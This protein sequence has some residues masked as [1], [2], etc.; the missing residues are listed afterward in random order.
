MHRPRHQEFLARVAS[1]PRHGIGLSV[2]VYSPDIGELVGALRRAQLPVRYLEMFKAHP[3]AL[4]AVRSNIPDLAFEYHGE[5]MW[6]T[7]P[8]WLTAYPASAAVDEAATHVQILG[9]SWL[10]HECASK[11]MAGYAFGTYLPPLLTEESA[12]ITARQA[13]WVQARLDV[14]GQTHDPSI[15]TRPTPL[16]LLETPPVTYVA[17]GDVEYA[18]FFRLVTEQAACGLVLDIGHIWTVYRYRG[19]GT[20]KDLPAFLDAFLDTFPLERVVQ[21]HVAGLAEHPAIRARDWEGS[22]Q[23]LDCHSAPVP[24]IVFDMLDRILQH[25]RLCHLRGLALEVD[26]KPVEMIVQELAQFRARYDWWEYRALDQGNA[27]D[28]FDASGGGPSP[29]ER[30][31][32]EVIPFQKEASGSVCSETLERLA[33][34]YRQYVEIITGQRSKESE[35][36]SEKF[37]V[38]P[39]CLRQYVEHYRP[40]EILEWG[41]AL[42]DMFPRTVSALQSRMISLDEFVSF[43]FQ[44]PR[45]IDDLYDFFLLKIDRFVEFVESRMPDEVPVARHEAEALRQSYI[46]V[47]ERGDLPSG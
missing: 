16:L 19:H 40:F 32:A 37:T 15:R 35:E 31:S 3:S 39:E 18:E 45:P 26:T 9:A 23:W 46:M 22:P 38:D 43:W 14:Q 12:S 33:E 34:G 24:S 25:P 6:M 44:N 42:Q 1:L 10:T 11:Q 7:Q 5:G 8:D 36:C 41:G 21:I 28:C 29:L 13:E 47:N 2:D 30:S 27:S 4:K 17:F 20:D